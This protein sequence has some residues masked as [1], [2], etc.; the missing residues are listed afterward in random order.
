M[1]RF[2]TNNPTC[3]LVKKLR[4]FHEEIK[5]QP[6]RSVP[7]LPKAVP[8]TNS[9]LGDSG[10]LKDSSRQKTPANSVGDKLVPGEAGTGKIAEATQT[11]DNRPKP[12]GDRP[13][14]DGLVGD[15]NG[16]GVDSSEA[17][18]T[19]KEA[20]TNRKDPR[21]MNGPRDNNTVGTG[22]DELR[23]GR[24]SKPRTSGSVTG[25]ALRT[26]TEQT[27][28]YRIKRR[29]QDYSL[30]KRDPEEAESD[31]DPESNPTP[32]H[33]GHVKPHSER[34][35]PT[36]TKTNLQSLLKTVVRSTPANE[37]GTKQS[38]F[39]FLEMYSRAVEAL[40][41]TLGTLPSMQDTKWLRA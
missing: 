1:T 6:I 19:K 32:A 12:L 24:T 8:N 20:D 37:E 31:G 2:A 35:L 36:L 10:T 11:K 17:K 28:A 9:G 34:L 4:Q 16:D 39:P 30:G 14:R 3:T 27:T 40:P 25:N 13:T 5:K 22:S 41:K 38:D 18:L 29:H 15:S 7:Q 33:L 21:S 23:E 26:N